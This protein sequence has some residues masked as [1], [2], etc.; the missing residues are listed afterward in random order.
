M[1][2]GLG[3]H[4]EVVDDIRQAFDGYPLREKLAGQLML[5]LHRGGRQPESLAVYRAF[6]QRLSAEL[7]TEPGSELDLLHRRILNNDPALAQ[8]DGGLR[9][10]FLPRAVPDFTGRTGELA[11]LDRIAEGSANASA[12]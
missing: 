11:E 7:G 10:R 3:R 8:L 12:R 6:S 4:A 9:R 5:A 1:E 2:L